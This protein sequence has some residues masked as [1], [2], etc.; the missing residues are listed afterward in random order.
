[1]GA[2][3]RILLSVIDK[4]YPGCEVGN[5]TATDG[6]REE[7]TTAGKEDRTRPGVRLWLR[8]EDR[9]PRPRME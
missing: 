2:P 9:I 3:K 5:Q 1:M 8:I 6:L 4:R 7:G